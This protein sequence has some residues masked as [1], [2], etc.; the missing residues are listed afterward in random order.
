MRNFV[1]RKDFPVDN[2]VCEDGT[3][4]KPGK[5]TTDTREGS[6]KG[7]CN[8]DRLDGWKVS[9]AARERCLAKV[10]IK[11]GEIRK[12][13]FSDS[14]RRMPIQTKV[15]DACL[16]NHPKNVAKCC[17]WGDCA[18]GAL[19]YDGKCDAALPVD[20][21]TSYVDVQPPRSFL[22]TWG[23]CGEPWMRGYCCKS[24]ANFNGCLNAETDFAPSVDY[25]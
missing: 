25:T 24:C 20:C 12:R 13:T 2:C 18:S 15:M 5:L 14:P 17:M 19:W 4:G 9:S 7:Y 21:G 8:A 16:S 3:L 1:I 11:Y 6:F 23:K 22:A 10:S